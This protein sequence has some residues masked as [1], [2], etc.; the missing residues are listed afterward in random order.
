[1]SLKFILQLILFIWF[2]TECW[3]TSFG[4]WLC[5][6]IY[7]QIPACIRVFLWVHDFCFVRLHLL[8]ILLSAACL[9][10]L[11]S[12]RKQAFCIFLEHYILVVRIFDVLPSIDIYRHTFEVTCSANFYWKISQILIFF[13]KLFYIIPWVWTSRPK[14]IVLFVLLTYTI[15]S[16]HILLSTVLFWMKFYHNI[17]LVGCCDQ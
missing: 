12:G 14:L 7:L 11:K 17:S 1:M 13:K 6:Y 4:W 2:T 16:S 5:L 3:R 15:I 10:S 8:P 9:D